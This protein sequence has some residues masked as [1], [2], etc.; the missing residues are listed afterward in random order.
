LVV[1]LIG[2]TLF[3]AAGAPIWRSIFNAGDIDAVNI[4][5]HAIALLDHGLQ[6]S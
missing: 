3:P 1:S 5:D 6:I 4:H 2:L